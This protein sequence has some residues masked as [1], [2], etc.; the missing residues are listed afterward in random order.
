MNGNQGHN[1]RAVARS[2]RCLPCPL[3]T[4]QL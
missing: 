3:H 2:W 4:G 1:P